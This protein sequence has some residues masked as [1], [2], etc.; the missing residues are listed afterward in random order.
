M[1]V[2]NKNKLNKFL[3]IHRPQNIIGSPRIQNIHGSIKLLF[4]FQNWCYKSIAP[5]FLCLILI[6]FL[7]LFDFYGYC[8]SNYLDSKICCYFSRLKGNS[9]KFPLFF[10]NTFM[11]KTERQLS[12]SQYLTHNNLQ[13][14]TIEAQRLKVTK[15][16]EQ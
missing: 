7:F 8:F 12:K 16:K 4:S 3:M 13:N 1:Q 2:E 11:S 10:P 9:I 15:L 6:Y 5:N 14:T